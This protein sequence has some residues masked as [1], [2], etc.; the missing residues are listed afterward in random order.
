[1]IVFPYAKINIGLNI[2]ERLSDGYHSLE[3]V[4]LPI[5]LYD[6]LEVLPSRTFQWRQTGL[7]IVGDLQDNLCVRAFELL[8]S[9]YDVGNVY[10]HLHK[11]IPFGAG[12]GGGSA[13]ATFVV[14]ALNSLFSLNLSDV[15]LKKIVSEL[16]SDCAFFVNSVPQLAIGRGDILEPIDIR[17]SNYQLVVIKP[18]IFVS[19]AEAYSTVYVSGDCGSLFSDINRPLS[20]WR[21]C[22]KNDF[23]RSIFNNYPQLGDIKE[24]LYELGAVYASMSGSGSAMYG[25][26]EQ[27]PKALSFENCEMFSLRI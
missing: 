22:I 2:V 23:E 21:R 26:F 12:L 17:L 19:T 15:E 27:E 13:D 5:P 1:M 20:E 7:N 16:G 9:S 3:T 6:V 4:M 10:M 25:I 14:K 11:R 24:Y 18:N 8:S